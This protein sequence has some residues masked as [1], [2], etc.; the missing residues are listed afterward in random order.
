MDVVLNDC[1]VG[2]CRVVEVL[3]DCAVE[4]CQANEVLSECLVLI[5]YGCTKDQCLGTMASL[6]Q[7]P[8]QQL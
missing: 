4:M 5:W 8:I 7:V 6:P 1:V 2:M 3:N